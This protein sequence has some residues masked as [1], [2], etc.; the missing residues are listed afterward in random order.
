[1]TN[2]NKLSSNERLD[3]E[4][5]LIAHLLELR[6]RLARMALTVGAVFLVLFWFSNDLYTLLAQPLMRHLP[7]GSSMIATEVASPFLAPL[8]LTLVA[9]IFLAIPVILYHLWA[10]VAPGLYKNERR[11][12]FPLLT[13]SVLL[14]FAGAA[15]AY[16]V[17][18]PVVFGFFTRVAPEGVAVMT[19][20][21]KYLDFV[22]SMFLAFGV[23]FETPVL[24]ILMVWAGIV[25]PADLAAKRRY[26][27]V[28]AFVIG[29]L[30][31]PDVI[32]QSLLAVPLW[33]LFEVGVIIS[34]VYGR[35]E[36]SSSQPVYGTPRG[37]QP[38]RQPHALA[39]S[40]RKSNLKSEDTE[41]RGP[42]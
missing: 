1:M 10:F 31:A 20:I 19:D 27:I 3:E 34:R 2:Q 39:T 9:S 41:D 18:F 8:K 29:M 30:I 12:V 23:A 33:I 13:S 21:T 38:I 40:E 7:E 37:T 36:P 26:V 35:K 11:L 16:Y 32:S 25:T 6:N 5:P 4:Q 24:I 17:V 28:G 42:E 15:F 22:L 14:F